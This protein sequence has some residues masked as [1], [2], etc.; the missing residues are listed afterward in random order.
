MWRLHFISLIISKKSPPFPLFFSLSWFGWM[1]SLKHY[2]SCQN[3]TWPFYNDVR[4]SN[5]L[6][7]FGYCD[8]TFEYIYISVSNAIMLHSIEKASCLFVSLFQ[9]VCLTP[10]SQSLI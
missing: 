10:P 7:F 5:G 2:Y 8:K 6:V 9:A 4:C 1:A 3:A